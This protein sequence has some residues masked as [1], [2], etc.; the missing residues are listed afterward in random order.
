MHNKFECNLTEVT[1]ATVA[2]RTK[3]LW[4]IEGIIKNKSNQSFKFDLRPISKHGNE[5]GKKGSI[6]TKADKMVF[7]S[8]DQ[9]IIIDLA[10]LHKYLKENKLEKVFLQDLLSNLE[11]NIVLPK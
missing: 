7:E 3:E 8:K 6:Q 4:D 1:K 5:L 2:Q 11:W 10:E 9:W